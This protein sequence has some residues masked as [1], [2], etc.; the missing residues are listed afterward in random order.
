MLNDVMMFDSTADSSYSPNF[1]IGNSVGRYTGKVSLSIVQ[2]DYLREF[3]PPPAFPL[4]T[5]E[6]SSAYAR[7]DSIERTYEVELEARS[8]SDFPVELERFTITS[9]YSRQP[10]EARIFE[11]LP[12]TY[13]VANMTEAVDVEAVTQY[14]LM[15]GITGT[16]PEDPEHVPPP[17]P[18]NGFRGPEDPTR[19]DDEPIIPPPLEQM[20]GPYT[21]EEADL[22]PTLKPDIIAP[23][24]RES[25][26]EADF[27]QRI[28]P[29]RGTPPKLRISLAVEQIDGENVTSIMSGARMTGPCPLCGSVNGVVTNENLEIWAAGAADMRADPSFR[30]FRVMQSWLE[31][32]GDETEPE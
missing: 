8:D 10:P 31:T 28:I 7:P 30:A 22:P 15:T 4:K 11:E 12:Q 20:N 18:E 3:N 5:D 9:E 17:L 2:R 16:H 6:I 13:D 26:S 14:K 19:W 27:E 32:R 23:E 25:S 29:G 1:V 21:M 24:L